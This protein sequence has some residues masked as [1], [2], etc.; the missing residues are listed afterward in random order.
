MTRQR[1][2]I[3]SNRLPITV[4]RNTTGWHLQPSCG[5]LVT[6]LDPLLRDSGGCWVGWTGTEYDPEVL[7]LLQEGS[8]HY[9]LVPVFLTA[10]EKA[11]FYHGCSNEIIWP[12]FHDLQSRCNFDPAYWSVY[13]DV[14]EKFAD[15]VASVANGDD[16]VWVHDYHLMLLA[17]A[18]RRRALPLKL[19]Y[20]HH[21]PFPPP[22]IFEKLPW[23]REILGALLQFNTL[24]FQTERDRRNFIACV[25]RY[26]PDVHIHRSGQ[27]VLA[28]G[29]DLYVAVG[30]FPI[31]IAYQEFATQALQPDVAA[32]TGDIRR[33]L[34][35]SRIVVGVDRLDYTKGIPQRLL[36]FRAL[37]ERYPELRSHVTLV[38]VVVPS[39]E[40][41]PCYHE[42]KQ[43]I[44][45]LVSQIN[46]E[47][48][49]PGWI[50]VHYMH[51]CLSPA[52]LVA[53]YRAADAALITSLKDGMNLVAKE[54]CAAN[55]EESGVLVLSEFAGAAGQ[56]NC[57]ALLV[58]P[59]DS[60]GVADALRR[61][62]LMDPEERRQRMHRMR[63]AVRKEDVF[64]WC[65]RFVRYANAG[66]ALGRQSGRFLQPATVRPESWS[67]Q[68]DQ[69]LAAAG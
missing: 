69:R 60:I 27:T 28:R 13:S 6:A 58:N 35:G 37:L 34:S 25:R 68:S 63:E 9:P 44:E 2:V 51:R 5:G 8:S 50:P 15:A 59:Y 40:E 67:R 30:S 7:N 36:A 48:A 29:K 45:L 12:L 1:L 41:I 32:K 49:V 18:L 38:Q 43:S 10:A 55:V 53:F 16:F 17:G 62:L 3:V 66:L 57:G 23:R 22:D 39:R 11:C 21:I 61:A 20:F 56:L 33:N 64:D 14:N 65:S 4:S 31:S 46:G 42:L 26:L 52:E 24:G 47:Y 54:F 19:A